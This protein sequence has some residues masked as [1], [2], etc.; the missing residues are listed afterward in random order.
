[1]SLQISH[2]SS[3]KHIYRRTYE[4]LLHSQDEENSLAYL[5]HSTRAIFNS[6]ATNANSPL[7]Y[8]LQFYFSCMFSCS[9]STPPHYLYKKNFTLYHL[10]LHIYNCCIFEKRRSIKKTTYVPMIFFIYLPHET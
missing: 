5:M 3:N 7:I 8:L 1:M 6:I 4:Q 2:S 10:S 9:L